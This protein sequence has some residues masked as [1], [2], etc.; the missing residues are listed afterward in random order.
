M[1][2]H[3]SDY[4]LGLAAPPSAVVMLVVF[5]AVSCTLGP[6]GSDVSW[7]R[8][9]CF[10]WRGERSESAVDALDFMWV[11]NRCDIHF[12]KNPEHN[13][14]ESFRFH[15]AWK[16]AARYTLVEVHIAS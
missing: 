3:D 15:K 7:R 12:C 6:A 2:A 13:C 14:A 8:L 16:P 10:P 4:S 9:R 5:E 1:Q 11:R